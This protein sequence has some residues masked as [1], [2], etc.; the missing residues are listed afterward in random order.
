MALLKINK[1]MQVVDIHTRAVY[2][3]LF[4]RDCGEIYF[5]PSFYGINSTAEEQ[6]QIFEILK[7]VNND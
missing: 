4:K 5:R 2:G 3:S 7:G 6:Q 1:E